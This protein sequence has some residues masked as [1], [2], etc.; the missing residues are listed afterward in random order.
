[1]MENE[2]RCHDYGVLPDSL[3][4]NG[5]DVE[6]C[7]NCG[8]QYISCGCKYEPEKRI[9]WSGE[10]PEGEIM[11][12]VIM[13]ESLTDENGA[14][15]LLSGMFKEKV[16]IDCGRCY[17]EGEVDDETCED[18]EGAGDY[19]LSVPVSWTTIKSIYAMAVKHLSKGD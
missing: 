11:K 9:K 10:W 3:H 17:G 7:P 13:P 19:S 8:G 12:T 15:G 4:T 6:R 16:I 1:M 14:K 18:C 2:K 5:C